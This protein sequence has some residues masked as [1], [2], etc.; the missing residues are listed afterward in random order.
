MPELP[1]VEHTRRNLDRWLTG[2]TITETLVH[3]PR[4]V[5][6]SADAFVRGTQGRKVTH[7]GRRG[8][9]LRFE[10]DDGAFVFGHLGMTGWFEIAESGSAPRRFERVGFDV[11]RRGKKQRVAYVDARRLG[12]LVLAHEDTKTWRKLGPDPLIEGIDVRHLR[13]ALADEKVRSIKEVLL[14]QTVIAGIGN[15]QSIEALWKAGIDPRSRALS[16]TP[17]DVTALARGLRWSIDR[18]LAGLE[19]SGTAAESLV[20]SGAANPFM[21]YGR[22]GTPCPRCRT[23]LARIEIGGRTTTFCPGCQQRRKAKR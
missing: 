10:L 9:W 22:K 6:P 19:K 14:D 3:D 4:A 18:T 1:E 12:G 23:T 11:T 20:S 7:V 15:I 8:K 16:L 13:S 2:A 21:I 17:K 5:K